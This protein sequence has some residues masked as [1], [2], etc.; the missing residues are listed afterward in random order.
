MA[1]KPVIRRFQDMPPPGGY[2]QIP[3]RKDLRPRGPSGYAIWGSLFLAICFGFWNLSNTS[4]EMRM[5]NAE[6]VKLEWRFSPF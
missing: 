6:T 1:S 4:Y 3:T 5:G 2:P